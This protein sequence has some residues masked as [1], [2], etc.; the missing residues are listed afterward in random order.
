MHLTI[1]AVCT[2]LSVTIPYLPR[3]L[4]FGLTF[5]QLALDIFY[6]DHYNIIVMTMQ[7]SDYPRGASA[8]FHISSLLL[9][10]VLVLGGPEA[11]GARPPKEVAV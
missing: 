5:S 10:L 2:T 8:G 11:T 6:K 3:T 4:L 1:S 7:D 9:L